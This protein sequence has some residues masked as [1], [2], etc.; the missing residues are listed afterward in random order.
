MTTGLAGG[1]RENE[2]TGRG[3][4]NTRVG[5]RAT[6]LERSLEGELHA[7]SPPPGVESG[8]R[9]KAQP[10]CPRPAVIPLLRGAGS[11]E[12]G[13]QG[14][15]RETLRPTPIWRDAAGRVWTR[16][17]AAT[18]ADGPAEPKTPR[19]SRVVCAHRPGLSPTAVPPSATD[20]EGAHT[21]AVAPGVGDDGARS[22]G[23]SGHTTCLSAGPCVTSSYVF[24]GKDAHV[25]GPLMWTSAA[26]SPAPERGL[27][28]T[29]VLPWR[30]GTQSC[31]TTL[32]GHFKRRNHHQQRN[33]DV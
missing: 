15:G 28:H 18:G 24:L 19:G 26:L 9:H 1:R 29:R 16:Q 32:R 22:L 3:S 30:P 31:D 5:T 20:A 7:L 17:L 6:A 21:A 27:S 12:W 8:A 4:G 2:P 14:K 25:V 33:T 23:A 11:E 10:Q 13:V